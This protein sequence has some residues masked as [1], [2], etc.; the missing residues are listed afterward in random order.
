MYNI[1]LYDICNKRF[2]IILII[3]RY[4]KSNILNLYIPYLI[5][6]LRYLGKKIAIIT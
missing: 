4:I 2:F 1:Y 6:A 3:F 5:L